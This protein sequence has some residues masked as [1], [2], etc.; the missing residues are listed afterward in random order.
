MSYILMAV[1]DTEYT[2]AANGPAGLV[3]VV[4]NTQVPG[5]IRRWAVFADAISVTA[6]PIIIDL[7][8]QAN[9]GAGATA[10]TPQVITPAGSSAAGSASVRPTTLPVPIG[11]A[12][13]SAEFHPQS[14][15]DYTFPMGQEPDVDGGKRAGIQMSTPN[16][17]NVR[18]K[19]WWS[20]RG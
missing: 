14:G 3:Q 19:I 4:M 16:T 7:V 5:K 20:E 1:A 15:Y 12:L 2:P 13:D 18:A 17:V 11:L 8:R 10:V 9:A 6:Q